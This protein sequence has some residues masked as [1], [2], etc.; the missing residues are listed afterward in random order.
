MLEPQDLCAEVC[1]AISYL[2]LQV[3]IYFVVNKYLILKGRADEHDV[4]HHK[5]FESLI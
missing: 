4:Q 3:L 5:L 1:T 2:S